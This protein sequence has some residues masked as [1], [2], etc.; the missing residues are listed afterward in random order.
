M[1]RKT[2]DTNTNTNTSSNTNSNKAAAFLNLE[3]VDA[4]G[5]KHKLPRGL[6]LQ[7]EDA[8]SNAMIEKAKED[9]EFKFSLEG[10]VRIVG[11]EVKLNIVL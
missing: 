2:T 6:A 5:N 3:L 7:L 9:S 8:V 1:G 4:N 10:T 11:Q